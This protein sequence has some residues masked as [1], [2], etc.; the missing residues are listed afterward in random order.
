MGVY[1]LPDAETLFS[2]C[3][4]LSEAGKEYESELYRLGRDRFFLC[5]KEPL[6]ESIRKES[7]LSPLS[8]VEEYAKTCKQTGFLAYIRERGECVIQQDAIA[9]LAFT[10][11]GNKKHL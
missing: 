1:R 8:F 5:I 4:A 10:E 2:L 11:K 3:A 7:N 9:R 6:E